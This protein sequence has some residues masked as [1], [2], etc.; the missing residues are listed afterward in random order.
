MSG[1]Q[2]PLI[3]HVEGNITSGVSSVVRGLSKI[4]LQDC[5]VQYFQETRKSFFHSLVGD[6]CWTAHKETDKGIS[7][8]VMEMAAHFKQRSKMVIQPDTDI[9][10]MDRSLESLRKVFHSTPNLMILRG[11]VD[12]IALNDLYE[13]MK[14]HLD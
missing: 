6:I 1:A 8:C 5:K 11:V 9:I 10:V 4:Q 14:N 12:S 13:A 3:I 7:A 2:K